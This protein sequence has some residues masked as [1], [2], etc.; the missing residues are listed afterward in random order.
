MPITKACTVGSKVYLANDVLV[1]RHQHWTD[2]E[3]EHFRE[4]VFRTLE[5]YFNLLWPPELKKLE[6]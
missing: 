5:E 4:S 1:F 3:R 2:A 6:K